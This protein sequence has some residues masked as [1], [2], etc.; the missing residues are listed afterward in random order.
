[1]RSRTALTVTALSATALL[2]T[3][4]TSAGEPKTIRVTVTQTVPATQ[5]AAASPNTRA[6]KMGTKKT[7]DDSTNDTHFTAQVTE[8]QQPPKGPQPEAP[9]DLG[10]DIW[11]TVNVKV[12]N[13]R[14]ATFTVGQTAWSLEYDDGTSVESTGLSGGDMPKPEYP[15][16]R[17]VKPGRCA[18]GLISYPVDSKKRPARVTYAPESGESAEWAVPST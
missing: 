11:A 16:D 7:L 15:M 6:L 17:A 8:Y 1:M 2:L 13:L 9:T 14:G 12:C 10:G 18:A 3:A 4:C 5:E